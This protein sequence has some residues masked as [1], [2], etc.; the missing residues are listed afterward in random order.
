MKGDKERERE[1]GREGGRKREAFSRIP[2]GTYEFAP[3]A[4]SWR[5]ARSA[6]ESAPQG[7][8]EGRGTGRGCSPSG[9]LIN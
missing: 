2:E 4:D 9:R 7:E 6:H 8:R 1:R 5:H 3:R